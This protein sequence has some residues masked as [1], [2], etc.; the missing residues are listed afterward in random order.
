MQSV[1]SFSPAQ[2]LHKGE[3]PNEGHGKGQLCTIFFSNSLLVIYFY[4]TNFHFLQSNDLHN[5]ANYPIRGH[6]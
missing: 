5:S 3:L 2:L 6:K 4:A 1:F